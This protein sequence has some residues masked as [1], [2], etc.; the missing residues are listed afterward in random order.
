MDAFVSPG[1]DAFVSTAPDAFVSSGPDV[2]V[3]PGTDAFVAP[4]TDAFL[5]PRPD[6]HVPL[7]TDAYTPAPDAYVVPAPDAYVP[8]AT[9]AGPLPDTGGPCGGGPLLT[10]YRDADGDGHGASASGTVMRCAPGGG[11]LAN[12]DDCDDGNPARYPGNSELCNNIDDDCNATVDGP[13]A[14]SSC[15]VSGGTG[16]CLAGGTCDIASCTAP[17]DDCDGAIGNGCE[18]NT[19]T[20]AAH[21]G[22]C[23]AACGAADTCSGSACNLSDIVEVDTGGYLGRTT[24][25][26]RANGRVACWGEGFTRVPVPAHEIAGITDATD[27]DLDYYNACVARSSG[28]P[29]C[30]NMTGGP[31]PS[32]SDVS[33]VPDAVQVAASRSMICGRRSTGRV[34]CGGFD[35]VGYAVTG[36]L[37]AT[38][39]A[40]FGDFFEASRTDGTVWNWGVMPSTSMPGA[41]VT[42][43]VAGSQTVEFATATSSGRFTCS[44]TTGGVSCYA[45]AGSGSFAACPTTLGAF[46]TEMTVPGMSGGHSQVGVGNATAPCT[47]HVCALTTGGAVS[48]WGANGF[49]QVGVAAPTTFVTPAISVAGLSSMTSIA[50]GSEYT[51]GVRNRQQV[52]CW[53]LNDGGQLGD[54]TLVNSSTPVLVRGL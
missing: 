6:A 28:S 48:C 24:C 4:G 5:D 52:Y 46:A 44:T 18:T 33:G 9:D 47:A 11:Y 17:F 16:R 3:A 12:N 1:T 51:C 21:C 23:G 26:R 13:A 8:P 19:S 15:I 38:D 30:W 35:G 25:I 29:R 42:L 53:G 45:I 34:M 39:L 14:D 36:L 43:A 40:S 2:F 50:A 27:L 7:G 49:G 32:F 22:S 10:F 37:N 41:P 20:T 31:S 54:G